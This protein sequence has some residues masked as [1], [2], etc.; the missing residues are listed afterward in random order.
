MMKTII[1]YLVFMDE[2]S[3]NR[4]ESNKYKGEKL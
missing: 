3:N 1:Y 4:I 2:D